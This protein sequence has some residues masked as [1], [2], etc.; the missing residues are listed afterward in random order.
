MRR[1]FLLAS[2]GLLLAG[3]VKAQKE[4]GAIIGLGGGSSERA[5]LFA[6]VIAGGVFDLS[7]FMTTAT[8]E[9][10]IA[11]EPDR[12]GRYVTDTSVDRCRDSQTGQFAGGEK[13][14]ET[15][16][17]FAGVFDVGYQ[18]RRNLYFGVGFRAGDASTPLLT[19]TYVWNSNTRFPMQAN[20]SAWRDYVSLT[21]RFSYAY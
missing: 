18:V 2:L 7:P 20:V 3:P 19:G 5:D 12:D 17:F 1:S 11:E 21:L 8:F 13:C 15:V 10:D 9:I 16:F 6:S 4:S 14:R